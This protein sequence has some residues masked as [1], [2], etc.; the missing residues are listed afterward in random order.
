MRWWQRVLKPGDPSIAV[1]ICAGQ[2]ENVPAL[3]KTLDDNRFTA[4]RDL[5]VY[6][7]KRR[8]RF[9]ICILAI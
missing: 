3:V 1:N 6:Q 5:G 9:G 2:P 4:K 8:R 7:N